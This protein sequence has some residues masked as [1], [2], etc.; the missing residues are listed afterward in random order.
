MVPAQ[1]KKKGFFQS[2]LILAFGFSMSA[3]LLVQADE[4]SQTG[5]AAADSACRSTDSASSVL[6]DLERAAG[7]K[8][9]PSRLKRSAEPADQRNSLETKYKAGVPC[10]PLM[11]VDDPNTLILC[12]RQADLKA[13]KRRLSLSHGKAVFMVGKEPV[14]LE[15]SLAELTLPGNSA[16]IIEQA[17]NGAMR[18]DHLAGDTVKITLK[19]FKGTRVLSAE[20]GREICLAPKQTSM[21]EL[22]SKDGIERQDLLS[23]KDEDGM[24]L[25]ESKISASSV[26]EKEC[27][28]Q[29]DSSSFFQVRR[30]V[31]QLRSRIASGDN[32]LSRT[33][34]Q[35][36]KETMLI[37]GEKGS[38]E[39]GQ[40]VTPVSYS[41][42][43]ALPLRCFDLKA[44]TVKALSGTD[45]QMDHPAVLKMNSGE[46]LFSA[47]SDFFVKTP[48]STIRVSAG[49]LLMISVSNGL[50]KVRTLW[51]NQN[52]SVTVAVKDEKFSLA[53]GDEAIIGQD[54]RAIYLA[55]SSDLLGRR[56][57]H[58]RNLADG[59]IVQFAEI[60]LMSLA[61]SSELLSRLMN[62]SDPCDRRICQKVNKMAAI[63]VQISSSKGMY[64]LVRP[65]KW[66]HE[67]RT[68]SD[69]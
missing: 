51:E 68:S 28:L 35:S 15:T 65:P 44:G 62:S 23:R 4:P 54:L 12:D 53:A 55:S 66:K 49:S 8:R 56:L 31:Y 1:M 37:L 10:I 39:N 58:H 3:S 47:S 16:L 30:K 36:G 7:K 5:K 34:R 14:Q 52:N 63:L 38:F 13:E 60:S 24:Q 32:K 67:L 45:L 19:R 2:G 64:E 59:S 21:S 25:A 46:A 22:L 43:A 26:L 48:Q 69:G 42:D 27:L 33:Q 20:S 17:E 11:L 40:R 50:C 41:E 6:I 61:Q 29:C 9:L 18:V 57:T